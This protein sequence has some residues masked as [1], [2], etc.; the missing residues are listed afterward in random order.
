[1]F[2]DGSVKAVR[3]TAELDTLTR[4]V[5]RNDGLVVNGDF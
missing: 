2:A 1:V 4:L 5:T 3:N